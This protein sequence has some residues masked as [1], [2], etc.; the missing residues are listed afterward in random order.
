MLRKGREQ[1]NSCLVLQS[2]ESIKHGSINDID[3]E[4]IPQ[5]V[6]P[7]RESYFPSE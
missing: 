1:G 2:L 6:K 3:W 7:H 4:L 5:D